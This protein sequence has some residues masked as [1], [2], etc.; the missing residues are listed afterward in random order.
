[1]CL[2]AL[3]FRAV[4]DAPLVVGANREELYTRGGE[5]PRI[6]DGPCPAVAGVDPQAGGTWLG[7]NAHGVLVAVTNRPKSQ[8]PPQPRSRGLLVRDLLCCASAASA[9]DLAA[10][11]LERNRYGGCN[12][13][14][15]DRDH[16]LVLHAGDWLRVRPMPPGLHVL[17]AHDVNDASDR[18]IG[19]A[20]WWL[21][22]RNYVSGEE[23]MA[24][25][26]ELC[27][28]T[29]NGS[30]PICLH[31]KTGG[32]V[33]SSIIMLGADPARSQ[34]LHAQGAPDQTPYADYSHLLR[35]A[36]SSAA[37]G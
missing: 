22:Q 23:C 20:L 34:Y 32:T 11:E 7:I 28:Q 14:C 2:L 19:H 3:F 13:V 1:M 25:L 18:R 8:I 12:I 6:L 37:R 5:P 36:L 16:A 17:T 33:S 24:A 27:G 21:G 4:E 35:Q 10:R 9:A 26:R 15:V 30:P 31:G 29:G